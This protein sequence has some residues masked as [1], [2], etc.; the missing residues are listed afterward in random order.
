MK[1]FFGF[2]SSVTFLFCQMNSTLSV[3]IDSLADQSV[4]FTS[5]V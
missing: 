4:T 3:A 2:R 1:I 5:C